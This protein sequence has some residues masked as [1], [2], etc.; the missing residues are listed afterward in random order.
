MTTREILAS[1][2]AENRP[3]VLVLGQDACRIADC[4]DAVLDLFL[5]HLSRPRSEPRTW[6]TALTAPVTDE[7]LAWLT[8]RFERNVVAES[9]E[10]ALDLPWSAVFTSSIDPRITARLESRGRQPDPI[11]ASD[12]YPTVP[13]STVRLPVYFLYGRSSDQHES[14]RPPRS[15]AELKRRNAR[16][17]APLLS[18]L[19]DTA[20]VLGTIVIDGYLPESDWLEL[21][22][23]F[24]AIRVGGGP[25]VLWFGVER[26]PQHDLVKELEREGSLFFE[27]RRL[28]A[29]VAELE[30]RGEL[31]SIQRFRSGREIV[32]LGGD[33]ILDV[34]PALRLRVEASAAIVDDDWTEQPVPLAQPARAEAFQQFHGN[35]GSPRGLVEGIMR[36]FA[37]ERPFEQRLRERIDTQLARRSELDRVVLLH[38]QSGTGKTLAC[39]RLVTRLRA[40][41]L[42]VLFAVGRVPLATD[43]DAFGLL[44]E[45]S[46]AP[47]TVVV[48]D[49]NAGPGLYMKLAE[50]LASRGRRTLV[51]G[52]S[53]RLE[54]AGRLPIELVEAHAEADTDERN[55]V[56]ELVKKHV[57]TTD[58]ALK[59]LREEDGASVFALLYRVLAYGRER[60]VSGVTGEARANEDVVR[61]RTRARRSPIATQLA[62]AL[63]TAGRH[64]GELPMFDG[65]IDAL[66]GHDAPGRLIDLIMVVGRL[67]LFVPLS[68]VMRTLRAQAT[69]LEFSEIAAIFHELDLFRWKHDEEGSELLIGPRLQLE[70]EVIAKRR[71]GGWHRE[72]QCILDLVENVR[73][74]GVD[75]GTERRF[76]FDL[77]YQV[78]RRGPRGD[79]LA[80]GYLSIAEAL[81]KLRVS[82]G[83]DDVSLILKESGFR[84]D[85]LYVHMNEPPSSA[86]R[87][88]ILNDARIAVDDAIR[89]ADLGEVKLSPRGRRDLFVERAALYGYL[90]VGHAMHGAKPD[91]VWADYQAARA[92]SRKAISLAP[93]YHPYDVGL[94]T[95]ADLLSS[96]VATRLG[97]TQEAELRADL[98]MLLDQLSVDDVRSDQTIQYLR[99][100]EQVGKLL[101][102]QALSSEARAAIKRENPAVATYLEAREIAAT[103]FV[104]KGEELGEAACTKAD[105]ALQILRKAGNISGQDGR[106]LSLQLE[107]EWISATGERLLGGERRPLPVEVARRNEL[108]RLVT[109]IKAQ[110]GGVLDFRLRFLEAVLLWVAGNV[111]AADLEWRTLGRETDLEV[112]GRTHRRLF[113]ACE[114]GSPRRFRGRLLRQKPNENW[115]VEVDS[116]RGSVNLLATDF[117]GVQLS[118]G[119]ATPEFAIAFNYLNPVAD[120]LDRY[121]GRS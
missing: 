92:A 35:L 27:P 104:K 78:D 1:T 86:E 87:D 41:R 3:C 45:N 109:A 49:A 75:G 105:E 72:V 84:R 33:K 76:L 66:F 68:L 54:D 95:T 14:A 82:H 37:I 108:Y 40:R 50:A 22:D 57:P 74:F 16:H 102:D 69:N 91:E 113:I 38:G 34:P 118:A 67:G 65:E 13:R 58:V 12:H 63:V 20:T 97:A 11:L 53:Y 79:E 94:W 47:A 52:T 32:S 23:L 96:R 83:F 106:C 77:L 39:A 28:G 8:E 31:T 59:T 42:P 88:R 111:K 26:A 71:L 30:A 93:D 116:L 90:A 114:D 24:G 85:Y 121:K 70:A 46:G 60:L 99:R 43:V 48:C 100:R 110:N 10:M 55:E 17:V 18:R 112:R 29:V 89:R 117:R 107:L 56:V 98:Y 61:K 9:L 120:P 21:D 44:A 64:S 19:E 115:V 62:Q 51:V 81:T 80:G 119:R 36:G 5:S 4:S 7:D 15:N 25:K 2:I 103:L 101:G 73:P 6:R